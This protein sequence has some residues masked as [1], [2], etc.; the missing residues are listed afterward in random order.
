M[1]VKVMT[2]ESALS[3]TFDVTKMFDWANVIIGALMP[4]VYVVMGLGLGFLIINSLKH[5][6]SRSV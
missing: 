5:A 4:V 3:I 6:F 2:T 1:E